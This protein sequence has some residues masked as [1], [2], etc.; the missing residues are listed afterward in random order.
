M[1]SLYV[2]DENAKSI[3]IQQTWGSFVPMFVDSHLEKSHLMDQ[4]G[5]SF[6]LWVHTF[7]CSWA[8]PRDLRSELCLLIHQLS[9]EDSE[10]LG[11]H[12]WSHK[13]DRA[14]SS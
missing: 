2:I 14:W 7:P 9:G 8:G 3:C 11:E 10:D 4:G 12:G 13:V 6:S 1:A 5:L